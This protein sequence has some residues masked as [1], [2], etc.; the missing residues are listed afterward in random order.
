ME[1]EHTNETPEGV[2]P[3]DA[4]MTDL[5]E[6]GNAEPAEITEDPDEG[7]SEET[8][9]PAK[10]KPEGSKEA[11]PAATTPES[12]PAAPDTSALLAGKFK[13]QE[14]LVAAY[15]SLQSE[16]GKSQS[17]KKRLETLVA[18]A[19]PAPVKETPTTEKP[20]T[21]AALIAKAALEEPDISDEELLAA[22]TP[23]I[24][25]RLMEDGE[26][27]SNLAQAVLTAV[28]H[29]KVR[30]ET[31]RAF[32]EAN[33]ELVEVR[34]DFLFAIAKEEQDRILSEIDPE[35][36]PAA[37]FTKMVLEATADRARAVFGKTK[38]TPT[39]PA[40]KEVV[41]PLPKGV[42]SE[43]RSA[44]RVTPPAEPSPEQKEMMDLLQ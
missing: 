37:T 32:Y 23:A 18:Q 22:L 21:I 1:T 10:A 11:A 42:R 6:A 40:P 28:E 8:P 44:G 13:S 12:K 30:T 19:T 16:Y 34:Q 31:M 5:M 36:T 9:A 15:L 14:D 41:K 20:K 26:I 27:N 17:A 4:D 43:G 38:G 2:E 25:A 24:K 29:E 3:T 39:K 33:P 35:T 7:K